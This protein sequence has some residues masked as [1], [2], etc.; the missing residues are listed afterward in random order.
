MW[1]TIFLASSNSKTPVMQIVP[2]I[3]QVE[4]EEAR[5]PETS[6]N[7]QGRGCSTRLE[8]WACSQPDWQSP[9]MLKMAGPHQLFWKQDACTRVQHKLYLSASAVLPLQEAGV[10]LRNVKQRN[11]AAAV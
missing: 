11:N 4:R 6:S 2:I 9:G 5:A 8:I 7:M 10:K 1:H 3:A